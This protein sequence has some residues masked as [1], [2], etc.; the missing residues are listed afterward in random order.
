MR[1]YSLDA[2][3]LAWPAAAAIFCSFTI[4]SMNVEARVVQIPAT[5]PKVLLDVPDDW[6]VL[7]IGSSFELRSPDKTSI[8]IIGLV[9]REKSDVIAWHKMATAKMVAFGVKFDP[10]AVAPPP[11]QR[12]AEATPAKP[13]LASLGIASPDAAKPAATV[14]PNTPVADGSDAAP[15]APTIFSGAPSIALP[16][17]PPAVETARD[18][19]PEPAFSLD[20]F[21]ATTTPK[22]ETGMT[23]K[24][25]LL[26]G[27]TLD[28]KPVD[29]QFFSYGLSKDVAFLLQQ[30]SQPADN[31]AVIIAKS[32]RPAS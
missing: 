18:E 2:T 32:V 9:K 17:K 12:A 4:G 3:Q 5:H 8:V 25:S 14:K 19:E 7:P 30:E 20:Q 6:T 15:P 22:I 10:K 23:V 1:L 26:H 16:E 11:V 13:N 31:R 21:S 29:A 24:A 27:A 28:G